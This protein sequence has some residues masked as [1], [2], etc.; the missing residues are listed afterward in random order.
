MK[1]KYGFIGFLSLLGWVGLFG[2][3]PLLLSFFAFLLFFKYFW[4]QPDELFIETIQKC[5]ACAFFINL[6]ITTG[7]T[8]VFSYFMISSNPLAGGAALGFGFHC[9]LCFYDK[10][11]GI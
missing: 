11:H 2:D 1:N 7:A 3:E 4:V 9:S 8:L 10:Y 5:A 6:L